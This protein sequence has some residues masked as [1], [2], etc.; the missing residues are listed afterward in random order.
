MSHRATKI[1]AALVAAALLAPLATV[2]SATALT[3]VADHAKD[4]NVACSSQALTNNN[5]I[6]VSSASVHREAIN[7]LVHYNITRGTGAGTTFDPR[8]TVTRWQMALF[9]QRAAG[10]VNADLGV[11]ASQGFTDIRNRPL[12]IQDAINQTAAAGVMRG[13]TAALF[14]PDVVVSRGEMARI[15]IDFL[16]IAP[17]S[18]VAINPDT[19]KITIADGETSDESFDDVIQSQPLFVEQAISALAELGIAK[20]TGDGTTF[21]PE[22]SVTRAQMASFITRALAFT[23]AR[24]VGI[25][26][27][28]A[29]IVDGNTLYTIYMYDANH[30]PVRN[31]QVNVFYV[32]GDTSAA[33]N[34]DG[35][36]NGNVV[37]S[38]ISTAC[39]IGGL[40]QVTNADGVMQI[41]VNETISQ[42]EDLTLYAWTGDSGNEVSSSTVISTHVSPA[43]V[44]PGVS[45]AGKKIGV[46]FTSDKTGTTLLDD[47]EAIHFNEQITAS[48]QVLD[49]DD[50][51]TA[52]G[53]RVYNVTITIE[54]DKGTSGTYDDDEVSGT[55]RIITD[56]NGRATFVFGP[57]DTMLPG[58]RIPTL[59]NSEADVT[60]T[61]TES[62]ADRNG[63]TEAQNVE[64]MYGL[65][66]QYDSNTADVPVRKVL[67]YSNVAPDVTSISAERDAG[68]LRASDQGD[69][70]TDTITVTALDQY[71][72]P[73]RNIGIRMRAVGDPTG[74]SLP[75]TN[76]YTGSDGTVTINYIR[77]N[78]ASD[79][80]TMQAHVAANSNGDRDASVPLAEVVVLWVQPATD[81]HATDLP[82]S[83]ASVATDE[84]VVKTEINDADVW[85]VVS[86]DSNDRFDL[87]NNVIPDGI[88]ANDEVFAATTQE[89]FES[90]LQAAI[91]AGH[92]H[93]GGRDFTLSW[94]FYQVGRPSTVAQWQL[95]ITS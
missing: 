70:I 51:P 3:G 11:P 73:I 87:K 26:I 31:G 74:I 72:D 54:D 75:Q 19:S 43:A 23:Q 57:I 82:V 42:T 18:G 58:R 84:I 20:G 95:V 55:Q 14:G 86:W 27:D 1:K 36:C 10:T 77:D 92:T 66:N 56:S 91:D 59:A 40:D 35:T 32:K 28:S 85:Q 48:L 94:T 68:F 67:T 34:S 24:P 60:I 79:E 47:N 2:P 61:I 71:A 64:P 30:Q 78:A 45:S 62:A 13:T 39:R 8:G 69:G 5:F 12:Y 83:G 4:Y 33:F 93:G 63:V 15:I 80:I 46:S 41:T 25:S 21:S 29:G 89:T 37:K 38:V 65:D 52:E 49:E 7:C 90:I 88:D 9:M 53:D 6:D 50:V 22:D 81:V 76:L 44:P 16:A 17:D